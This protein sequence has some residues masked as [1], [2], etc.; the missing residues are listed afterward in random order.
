[1]LEVVSRPVIVAG[2]SI[3]GYIGAVLAADH[4]ALASGWSGSFT[5]RYKTARS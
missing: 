2:N 5:V 4:P 3:G 1:M